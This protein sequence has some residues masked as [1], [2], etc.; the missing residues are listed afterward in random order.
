MVIRLPF[1]FP[2]PDLMPTAPDVPLLLELAA[3][4]FFGSFFFAFFPPNRPAMSRTCPSSLSANQ[5]C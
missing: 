5:F 1:A 4:S 2:F 3:A